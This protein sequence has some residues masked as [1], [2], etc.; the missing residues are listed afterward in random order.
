MEE[1]EPR[2]WNP[3]HVEN[4]WDSWVHLY[5]EL[6]RKEY[7]LI[8]DTLGNLTGSVTSWPFALRAWVSQQS[9]MFMKLYPAFKNQRAIIWIAVCRIRVSLMLHWN[10]FHLGSPIR[11]EGF[12]EKY[13]GLW[14]YVLKPMAGVFWSPLFH[15]SC[16]FCE[17][18]TPIMMGLQTHHSQ[19]QSRYDEAQCWTKKRGHNLLSVWSQLDDSSHFYNRG[20]ENRS[21]LSVGHVGQLSVWCSCF[22]IMLNFHIGIP[23]HREN[24]PELCLVYSWEKFWERGKFDIWAHVNPGPHDISNFWMAARHWSSFCSA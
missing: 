11:Y 21:N 8:L 7:D 17:L 22:L 13:M 20:H 5:K 15:A 6:V 14:T 2:L 19:Q 10:L 1:N 18:C 12:R 4:Q 3:T 9:S 23:Y 24:C 16:R